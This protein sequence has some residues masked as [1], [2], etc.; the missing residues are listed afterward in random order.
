MPLFGSLYVFPGVYKQTIREL[1]GVTPPSN[2]RIPIVYGEAAETVPV[3]GFQMIRA[4]SASIDNR[5]KQENVSDRFLDDNDLLISIDGASKR[6]KVKN[7]PIV[8]GKGKGTISTDPADVQVTINGE[9]TGVL[10]LE[11]SKGIVHLSQIPIPGDVVK[12]TYFYDI[13]DTLITEE[14]LSYQV[15]GVTAVFKVQNPRIVDGTHGGVTTTT[16]TDVKAKVNGTFVTVSTVDGLTG[17]VTLAA[18]PVALSTVLLT[19]YSS[20]YENTSDPF[21]EGGSVSKINAVGNNPGKLDYIDTIDYVLDNGTLNWGSSHSESI[22]NNTPGGEV[23]DSSKVSVT[24]VDNYRYAD[25]ATGTVDGVNKTFIT[26]SQMMDGSGRSRPTDDP[27]LI[28]AY[29]G[30]TL[31]AALTAGPK[32]VSQL[33]GSQRKLI[34][35]V[36]PTVGQFVYVDYYYNML[37][38]AS[39]NLINKVAGVT[40]TGKYKIESPDFGD[41]ATV[42]E[43]VHTVADAGFAL[44]GIVYPN[45]FS[46]AQVVPGVAVNETIT[47]TFT[48]ARAFTVTSTNPL[49]SSGTGEIEKTYVDAR[50]GFRVSVL[51]SNIH[52]WIVTPYNFAAADLLKFVV[53]VGANYTVGPVPNIQVPGLWVVLDDTVGIVVD[54]SLLLKTFNKAGK[55]P[56]VGDVY[57]VDYEYDKSLYAPLPVKNDKEIEVVF[58]TINLENRLSLALRIML[59]NGALLAY[60]R[61]LKR[62]PGQAVATS[63][64]YIAAIDEQKAKLKGGTNQYIHVPLTGNEDVLGFLKNHVETQSNVYNGNRRIGIFGFDLG[65]EPDTAMAIARSIHSER[66]WG[67]YPDGVIVSYLDRNGNEIEVPVP[68]SYMACALAGRIVSPVV[69]PAN[70]LGPT[71][72]LVDMKRLIRTLDVNTQKAIIVSGLILLADVGTAIE[73]V[74]TTTTNT[75]DLLFLEPTVTLIDDEIADDI[76]AALRQFIAVKNLAGS[77][78]NMGI[79]VATVM[80]GKKSPSRTIIIDYKDISVVNDPNDPRVTFVDVAYMPVFL[81]KWILLTLHV[82]SRI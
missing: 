81:R 15:D 1:T 7:L 68:G 51:D 58:G 75:D 11:G 29:V 52:G 34:L 9:V 45:D 36:A 71:N 21:D 42:A 72:Q 27:S 6:F 61:Q 22:N 25:L 67:V 3:N 77:E 37:A 70:A 48:S 49:G 82:R 12:V 14:D 35:K 74:D 2:L 8:D 41:L 55:E 80:E 24:L 33:Y 26:A 64:S 43:G 57:F 76:A 5:S 20:N 63:E 17:L 73:I 54:D 53:T 56:T 66:M 31:A 69:D 19:Y 10:K 46:D 78:T 50:T 23:F 16:T 40:P 39:F 28:I 4:S 38:D 13:R 30:T 18:V 32:V 62:A 79:A 44:E 65:T 47:L 59:R 60:G